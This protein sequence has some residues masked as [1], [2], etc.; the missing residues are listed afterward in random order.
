M[1]VGKMLAASYNAYVLPRDGGDAMTADKAIK[2]R[3]GD[4]AALCI[5]I[6]QNGGCGEYTVEQAQKAFQ[7]IIKS[8]R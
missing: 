7:A 6:E 1:S 8:N 2:L 5:L 4:R 3:R